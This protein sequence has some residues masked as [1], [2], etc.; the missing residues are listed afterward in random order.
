MISIRHQ[1]AATP[2][3]AP[4]ARLIYHA[5]LSTNRS[6]A[7]SVAYWEQRYHEG[8]SSGAGS[9]GKFARFKAQFLNQ[10]VVEHDIRIGH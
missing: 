9:Y 2:I 5:L 10:F 3:V 8:G 7:G 4:L 1:I 6:F